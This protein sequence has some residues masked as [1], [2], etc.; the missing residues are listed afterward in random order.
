MIE[1]LFQT[2]FRPGENCE[3]RALGLH[4]KGPWEGYAKGTVSGY[5]NDPIKFAKAATEINNLGKATGVYFTL[6]P[7]NP[8]LLARANNRLIVPKATTTDDQVLCHRWLLIDTDPTRPTGISA[9][10]KEIEAAVKCRDEIITF[11]KENGF[12]EP[13][14]AFS[15]NGGHA[16]YCLPDLPNG[17]E[18]S[19]LKRKALQ[20]LNDKFGQTGVEVDEKVFNAARIAKLYGTWARKG[21]STDDRPHRRSYLEHAPDPL[22]PITLERLQWLALQAPQPEAVI[23]SQKEKVSNNGTLGRLDVEAYLRHYGIET[24]RVKKDGNRTIY[25]LQ[26]CVFNPEHANNDASIV[27]MADGKLSYQCFHNTCKGRTWAE[28]RQEI[29]GSD[30]LVR[31][32]VGYNLG[33]RNTGTGSNTTNK[34]RGLNLSDLKDQFS[35]EVHYLW[36]SHFPVGMPIIVNGREGDG[37]TTVCLQAAKEILEKHPGGL[38]VWL[39]TEGAV[40]DTI[41]KA[42]KLN[43]G[44][45]FLVAQKSDGTFKFDFT[46]YDDLRELTALLDDMGNPVLA[47]FIDSLRGATSLA[48]EDSRIK[49]VIQ[50]LN[51]LVCDKHK[52]S[53]IYIHHFSK[54][55]KATLLDRSTGTTAITSSVRVVLSVLPVS[56]YKRVIKQA[57]SNISATMPELEVIE[58]DGKIIIRKPAMQSEETLTDGA[59][60]FLIN[61]FKERTTILTREIFEKGEEHGFTSH[62]LKKV[63]KTLGIDAHQ[64]K[65]GAPWFWTWPLYTENSI[66]GGKTEKEDKKNVIK[67]TRDTRETRETTPSARDTRDTRENSENGSISGKKYSVHRVLS[68]ED[69]KDLARV[70]ESNERE[71]GDE[72]EPL[73]IQEVVTDDLRSVDLFDR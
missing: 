42:G 72:D 24:A 16:L 13:I 34:A 10:D 2:F 32:C 20:T 6:N 23:Y 14:K 5:F 26:H 63:K 17:Q 47:V 50:K 68:N 48:D 70:R 62:L 28:A 45:R 39:A 25:G 8:A 33:L 56:R 64:E 49:N 22:I 4:G 46:R 31:F 67:S 9:T 73:E 18:I 69:L 27:Q 65:I 11:L 38:V 30:N 43:M 60:E 55:Q 7:V 71:P 19:D 61:L 59:E 66:P 51:A 37:K 3:I 15:G 52:A 53:L 44:D 40:Q 54:G 1:K 12:P 29:S 36:R 21:D 35:G 58:V 57:K 41:I